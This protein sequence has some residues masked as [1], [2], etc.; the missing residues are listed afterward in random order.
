MA[1]FFG[2]FAVSNRRMAA[3]SLFRVVSFKTPFIIYSVFTFAK[4]FLN[5]LTQQLR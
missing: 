5:Y 3:T 4:D 1:V 2:R